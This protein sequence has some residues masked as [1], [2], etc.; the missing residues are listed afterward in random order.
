MMSEYAS[1]TSGIGFNGTN[2]NTFLHPRMGQ[3]LAHWMQTCKA[4]SSKSCEKHGKTAYVGNQFT[5]YARLALDQVK[6]EEIKPICLDIN[7]RHTSGCKGQSVS[8]FGNVNLMSY[9]LQSGRADEVNLGKLRVTDKSTLRSNMESLD[10]EIACSDS[11]NL[12]ESCMKWKS[13]TSPHFKNLDDLVSEHQHFPTVDIN[14]KVGTMVA[15]ME[16]SYSDAMLVKSHV[17]SSLFE[18]CR[19]D[20]THDVSRTSLAING[21]KCQKKTIRDACMFSYGPAYKVSAN[22]ELTCMQDKLSFCSSSNKLISKRIRDNT[23]SVSTSLGSAW[24]SLKDG[25]TYVLRE[26]TPNYSP[27]HFSI[28]EHGENIKDDSTNQLLLGQKRCTRTVCSDMQLSPSKVPKFSDASQHGPRRNLKSVENAEGFYKSCKRKNSVL[29]AEEMSLDFCRIELTTGAI[30][31]VTQHK[32]IAFSETFMMPAKEYYGE[33]VTTTL[34][35]GNFT[36]DENKGGHGEIGTHLMEANNEFSAKADTIYFKPHQRSS[37]IVG[38]TFSTPPRIIASASQAHDAP[39]RSVEIGTSNRVEPPSSTESATSATNKDAADHILLQINPPF[40]TDFA[41]GA[42][43]LLSPL[44]ECCRADKC[45][46]PPM[47]LQIAA[48]TIP[49][50]TDISS[51]GRLRNSSSESETCSRWLKCLQGKSLPT[52]RSQLAKT[53]PLPGSCDPSLVA[54]DQPWVRSWRC[55]RRTVA[56]VAFLPVKGEKL[57]ASVRA[58]ALMGKAMKNYKPCKFRRKEAILIWTT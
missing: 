15:S 32:D 46:S 33:K 20:H 56:N 19:P 23:N 39:C 45:R 9:A 47:E 14:G 35:F 26:S 2:D 50:I 43:L 16:N 17:T 58:M 57:F 40:G 37:S 13:A 12:T 3:W 34:P 21:C 44:P 52:N 7:Q 11:S 28:E 49:K 4:R 41:K 29:A 10:D 6:S 22:S 8:S 51:H 18:C 48:Q 30:S 36:N 53:M 55:N 27:F 42:P 31:T 24:T 1:Q 25:S 54:F 5:R 38:K